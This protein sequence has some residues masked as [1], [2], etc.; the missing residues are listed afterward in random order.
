MCRHGVQFPTISCLARWDSHAILG[1]L[2][3]APLVNATEEFKNKGKIR[4]MI[5]DHSAPDG[6]KAGKKIFGDKVFKQ[7]ADMRKTVDEHEQDLDRLAQR[8]KLAEDCAVPRFVLSDKYQKYHVAL[9]YMDVP[10]T[11]WKTWCGW[12]YGGS[13]FQRRTKVPEDIDPKRK[14]PRC[15]PGVHGDTD[16]SE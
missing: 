12:S 3:D 2:K 7:L 1:Y 4:K 11:E 10:P 8:M 15:F 14:C 6:N 5:A 16:A 13:V 9:T